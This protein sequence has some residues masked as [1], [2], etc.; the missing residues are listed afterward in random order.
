MADADVH[1]C[2]DSDAEFRIGE[3]KID[4]KLGVNTHAM[5]G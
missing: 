4:R 1:N 3:P 5:L 2:G